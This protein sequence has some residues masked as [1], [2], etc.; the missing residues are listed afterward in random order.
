[1]SPADLLALIINPTTK[2]ME[3]LVDVKSDEKA[4]VLLLTIAQQESGIEYRKQVGGPAVSW[5]QFESGGGVKGVLNYPTTKDKIAKICKELKVPCTQSDV[6]N[7]MV[8]NDVLSCAMARLL[9][10]TDARVLPEM[11]DVKGAWNYYLE[12]WRPGKPHPNSW[13]TFY[14]I[15]RQALGV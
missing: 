10:Y 7:A 15:S 14:K 13:D 5:W 11:G 2:W 3:R 1:M 8:H 6:Y 4:K 12:N 9:L